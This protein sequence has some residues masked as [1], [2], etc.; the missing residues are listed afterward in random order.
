MAQ[1]NVTLTESPVASS[2]PS[3]NVGTLFAVGATDQGPS[4]PVFCQSLT[5]YTN[6]YGPRST[7]SAPLFDTAEYFFANG[8][9]DAYFQRVTDGTATSAAHTLMDAASHPTVVVTALTPGVDGNQIFVQVTSTAVEIE[10]S[11]GDILETWP[12]SG[13]NAALL[14]AQ[15][16]YVTF[17]QSAGTGFTT[18]IP[19][20]IS[21]VALSGGA[22]ATDLTDAS[23]AG[24]L[25]NFGPQLGPGT[26]C[27]PGKTGATEAVAIFE[28]ALNNNRFAVVE[29]ATA[30][31]SAGAISALTGLALPAPSTKAGIVVQGAP[32]VITASGATKTIPAS[33]AVAAN[34][35]AV[36]ATGTNDAAAFSNGI[37]G[38]NVVGFTTAFANVASYGTV[39]SQ[40]DANAMADAGLCFF[41]NE[42][43]TFCLDEFVTPDTSDSI[44]FE[45]TS[46]AGAMILVANA[47]AIGFRYKGI[48][49]DGQGLA[50]NSLHKD[51]SAIVQNLFA[52][53]VLY[54]DTADDAAS[55]NTGSPVNTPATAQA[56]QL[57]ANIAARLSQY[58]DQINIAIDVVSLT[59]S[60]GTSS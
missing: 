13:T 14:S 33:A 23:F 30:S 19:A 6:T 32:I 53:N 47:Q 54:G 50:A 51:L 1:V 8:G 45:A 39:W 10:D 35:A 44:F 55:I 43:G 24:A 34:R 52:A 38:S 11:A 15:S 17:T 57:N 59:Q 46:W 22:D 56:G 41:G 36:A 5:A 16:D 2:G 12:F 7:L 28:H 4:T 21:A 42:Y 40:A 58:A 31:T 27:I 60:V 3:T 37:L 9:S 48:T 26:V 20:V 49:I 25:A 18:A 29:Q